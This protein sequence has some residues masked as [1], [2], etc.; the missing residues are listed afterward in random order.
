[1]TY[2]ATL[3]SAAM[4]VIPTR[5]FQ[6]LWNMSDFETATIAFKLPIYLPKC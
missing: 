6:T 4:F 5:K 2:V 1:M 3:L